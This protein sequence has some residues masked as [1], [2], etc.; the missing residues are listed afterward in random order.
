MKSPAET[1][2]TPVRRPAM[3]TPAPRLRRVRW[4]I[5]AAAILLLLLVGIGIDRLVLPALNAASL[6]ADGRG[7]PAAIQRSKTI[8]VASHVAYPGAESFKAGTGTIEG[9]DYDLCQA[10]AQHF[11]PLHC[12]FVDTPTAALLPNLLAG[13]A[14]IVMS[15]LGDSV[16]R[17]QSVDLIDYFSFGLSILVRRTETSKI[18]TLYDLCGRAVSVQ[19]PVQGDFAASL[20]AKCKA[21]KKGDVRIST[22][23]LRQL[24]AGKVDAA[25]ADYPTAVQLAAAHPEIQIVGKPLV[26]YPLDPKRIV[27]PWGIAVR[28][29]DG[30]LRQALL[31]SLRA[32]MADGTYHRILVKWGV[33]DGALKQLVV[34]CSAHGNCP[35]QGSP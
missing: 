27:A 7:L 1:R 17:E 25:L 23:D 21:L 29:D 3:Y 22:S 9:V 30:A 6:T 11:G 34:N 16:G 14:D 32:L 35:T 12:T 10:I 5:G 24:Q 19:F 8:T 4:L 18:T 28:K 13:H 15:G 26:Q 31:A 20:A 2:V 33:A